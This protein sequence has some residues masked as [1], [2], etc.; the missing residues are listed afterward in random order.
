MQVSL[1]DLKIGRTLKLSGIP[2]VEK[3]LTTARKKG[4]VRGKGLEV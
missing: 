4:L 1:N 2:T 3:I